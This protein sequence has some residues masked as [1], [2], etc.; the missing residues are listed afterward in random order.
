MIIYN[1]KITI[2]FNYNLKLTPDTDYLI[3]TY[4]WEGV[5]SI[6][7]ERIF[8]MILEGYIILPFTLPITH[9]TG[10]VTLFLDK[11]KGF[12]RSPCVTN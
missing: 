12:V 4:G 2:I 5:V 10:F 1:H 8:L 9:M 6:G 11:I 7:G 3:S